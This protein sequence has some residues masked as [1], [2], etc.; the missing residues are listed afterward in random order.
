MNVTHRNFAQCKELDNGTLKHMKHLPS[1][2]GMRG[3]WG[4]SICTVDGQRFSLGD[5]DEPFPMQSTRFVD[6]ETS[7]V[8]RRSR[9][10]GQP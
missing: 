7:Y 10:H 4:L 6:R 2:E 8:V 5:S 3:K 9:F 1:E